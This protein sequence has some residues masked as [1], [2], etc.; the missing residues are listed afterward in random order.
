MIQSGYSRGTLLVSQSHWPLIWEA[1]TLSSFRLAFAA[2]PVVQKGT[3]ELKITSDF[4]SGI[5]LCILYALFI[6]DYY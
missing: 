5:C 3:A 4:L 1:A 2:E 6:I